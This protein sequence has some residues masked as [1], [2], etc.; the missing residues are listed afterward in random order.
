MKWE[1]IALGCEFHDGRRW[2]KKT[3][4]VSPAPKLSSYLIRY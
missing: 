1:T 3:S 4:D 2:C